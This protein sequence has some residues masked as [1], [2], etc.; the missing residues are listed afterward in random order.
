MFGLVYL[1]MS[2]QHT[3]IRNYLQNDQFEDEYVPYHLASKYMGTLTV[4][5]GKVRCGKV[6]VRHKNAVF[7]VT[8]FFCKENKIFKNR[9]SKMIKIGQQLDRIFIFFAIMQ[10]LLVRVFYNTKYQTDCIKTWTKRR[11][12]SIK[13]K[14]TNN[15][16]ITLFWFELKKKQTPGLEHHPLY[17]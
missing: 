15:P 17:T 6:R 10:I 16:K 13:T 4:Q 7:T 2:N 12:L 3:Q 14:K 5:C 9:T 8:F 11:V 1:L